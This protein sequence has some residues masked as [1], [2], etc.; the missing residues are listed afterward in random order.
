MT[1]INEMSCAHTANIWL[2]VAFKKKSFIVSPTNIFV[3]SRFRS[4]DDG[5]TRTIDCCHVVLLV[6]LMGLRAVP[7]D[8]NEVPTTEWAFIKWWSNGFAC[9]IGTHTHTQTVQQRTI[10][11]SYCQKCNSLPNENSNSNKTNNFYFLFFLLQCFQQRF[12]ATKWKHSMPPPGT[13]EKKNDKCRLP[14]HVFMS[15]EEAMVAMRRHHTQL[16]VRNTTKWRL[17]AV[18]NG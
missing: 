2:G 16:M 12:G 14:H 13:T 7:D 1:S 11:A 3:M 4:T 8:R 6:C 10:Y 5:Q 9:A 17:I 15:L 18:T